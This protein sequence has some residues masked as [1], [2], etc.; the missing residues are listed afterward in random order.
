[1]SS[2]RKPVTGTELLTN[3]DGDGD[4][5]DGETLAVPCVTRDYTEQRQ[6]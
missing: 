1:M 4:D 3:D 5:R 6:L 2:A